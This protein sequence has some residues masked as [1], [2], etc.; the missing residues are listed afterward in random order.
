MDFDRATSYAK[1]KDSLQKEFESFLASLPGHVTLATVTPR[2]VCCFLI[3][4]DK[5]GK[6]QI[7]RNGCD[8]IGKKGRFS[9]G[10]AIR[11][12]YKTIDSYIGKLRAILHSIGR[13]G[14]WDKRLGL[15]NPASDKSVKDFLRLVTVEQLQA[16]IT[17]K[18]AA[19]FFVD[20]LTQLCLH[21]RKKSSKKN[22]RK[23][24]AG[25]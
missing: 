1:Q 12:S 2:D 18:Q 8:H 14:E 21:L 6:T 17:P 9:C 7:H 16:R 13:D 20:K 10:C 11:L 5:D 22:S 24:T 4:K 19:P 25:V 3:V 23:K 15:G